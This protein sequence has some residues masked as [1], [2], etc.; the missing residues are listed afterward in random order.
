MRGFNAGLAGR[1]PRFEL[2]ALA[3]AIRAAGLAALLAAASL[4]SSAFAALP[5]ASRDFVDNHGAAYGLSADPDGNLFYRKPFAQQPGRFSTQVQPEPRKLHAAAT[6]RLVA[7]FERVAGREPERALVPVLEA[8][9]PAGHAKEAKAFFAK[10]GRGTSLT[11]LGRNV[12]MDL[13]TADST[14]ADP[15]LK[16][17][18]PGRSSADVIER[19]RLEGALKDLAVDATLGEKLFDGAAAPQ[20]HYELPAYDGWGPGAKSKGAGEVYRDPATG[21]L[22]LIVAAK[23]AVLADRY[24]VLDAKEEAQV[25]KET[26]LDRSVIDRHG[27]RVVR[28]IDNLLEVSVPEAK[29]SALGAALRQLGVSA[30]PEAVVQ[31]ANVAAEALEQPRGLSRFLP[32]AGTIAKAMRALRSDGTRNLSTPDS[33]SAKSDEVAD[34][35]NLQGLWDNGMTGKGGIVADIDSGLDVK[36]PDFQDKVLAYIDLVQAKVDSVGHGTHTAGSIAG[37]G[38]ASGGKYKGAAP[39]AKLVVIQVFGAGGAGASELAILAAMKIA[40][41]LPQS[42]RPDVANMSLGIAGPSG[43]NLHSTALYA[44]WLMTQG[45]LFLSVAAGNSGPKQYTIGAPGNAR[46]VLTVTGTNKQRK[47]PFFPSRGPVENWPRKDYNKPDVAAVAGDVHRENPCKYGP[48]GVIAPRSSDENF[49][50][51]G[52][53]LCN[54]PDNPKYRYMSGTSMATPQAAGVAQDV[55]AYLKAKGIPYTETE[56]KA[57][58]LET[59]DDLG[60]PAWVQGAGLINGKRLAEA[61]VKRIEAGA[62]AGNVA[63]LLSKELSEFDAWLLERQGRVARTSVGLLDKASGHLVNTEAEVLA[64]RE[65]ARRAWSAKNFADKA[66]LKLEFTFVSDGTRNL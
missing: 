5:P 26:G 50:A 55:I 32:F 53:D 8:M 38:E 4:G 20:M 37:S 2:P 39:D 13:L 21:N 16:V 25:Y 34:V 51:A 35:L 58:I 63:L 61:V 15:A 64:L 65:E 9:L 29:F 59:A 1:S 54:A 33:P 12:L 14:A 60:E 10:D 41:S 44:E 46:S 30:A 24:R 43:H 36:H 31:M 19:L 27:G 11:P 17:A 66:K 40:A 22:H 6:E 3:G 48:G 56:I 7:L 47:F 49:P 42:M 18:G 57:L 62:P 52:G 45:K 23:N 28:A